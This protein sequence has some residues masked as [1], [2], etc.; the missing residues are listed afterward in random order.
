MWHEQRQTVGQ[1]ANRDRQDPAW[2][3]VHLKGNFASFRFDP[4]TACPFCRAVLPRLMLAHDHTA[5]VAETVPNRSLFECAEVQ[6]AVIAIS[7]RE[8]P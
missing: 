8:N 1:N 3:P 4:K 6:E 7:V 2:I 5:Q